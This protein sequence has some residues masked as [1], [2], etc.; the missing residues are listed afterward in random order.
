M[1]LY[2]FAALTV[3]EAATVAE[4]LEDG[5]VP[6]AL[7]QKL[8]AATVPT[9]PP[10]ALVLHDDHNAHRVILLLDDRSRPNRELE[11]LRSL[12][13]EEF[14]QELTDVRLQTAQSVE[15]VRRIVHDANDMG[16]AGDAGPVAFENRQIAD[17]RD[18]ITALARV[19]PVAYE[20]SSG[21]GN[22][23]VVIDIG[24]TPGEVMIASGSGISD[25]DV[26]IFGWR[27]GRQIESCALPG[28]NIAVT[29]LK[30]AVTA[31][32]TFWDNRDAWLSQI[33]EGRLDI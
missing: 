11:A 21:S 22:Y 30:E 29:S 24:A 1:M 19:A 4:S 33:A 13:Y 28:G 25:C 8:I 7:R 3:E 26:F 9:L 20:H 14:G 27:D 32:T 17:R 5:G 6:E 12:A 10:T 16:D 31:F 23:H 15:V 2:I 18:L